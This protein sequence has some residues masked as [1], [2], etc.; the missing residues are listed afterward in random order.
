MSTRRHCDGC[1]NAIDEAQPHGQIETR[2][3]D[4]VRDMHLCPDCLTRFFRDFL[5]GLAMLRAV[6]ALTAI[7]SKTET[8]Q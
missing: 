7:E 2:N 3:V 5:G 8:N 1:G 4:D 6:A